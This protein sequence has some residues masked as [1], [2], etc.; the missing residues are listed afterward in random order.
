MNDWDDLKV[1]VAAARAGS[2]TGAAR[3]LGIDAATVG[4]RIARLESALRSTLFIRSAQGLE[5]TASGARLFQIGLDAEAAM[6]AAAQ[7]GET[8]VIGGTVRISA[9]EGFGAAVLAPA[10][11]AFHRQ[12]PNLRIELAAHAGF[13]SP[14]RRE[15][16]MA[17]TLDTPTDARLSAEPLTDYQLALYAAPD[18]LARAGAP[19]AVADLGRFDLVGYIDDLIYAAALKYLEE[20]DPALRPTLSSSS[21]QAQQQIIAA[22]GGIGVLPCF[23]AQGLT[24]VLPD[25]VLLTRRF[26]ISTHKELSN[27]ARLKTLRDWMKALVIERRG[28]LAPF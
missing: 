7:I 13:L 6:T 18:Y 25:K 3:R 10:L 27:T 15:V 5:L 14:T 4:R 21:I 1:F 8:D 28:L 23:M 26:W 17:V 11:P 9:S 16:D 12:R 20:L 22:G 19:Q 2:Q 24:R